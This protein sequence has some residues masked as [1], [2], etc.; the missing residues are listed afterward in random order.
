[1]AAYETEA[2]LEDKLIAQLKKL[3]YKQVTV[4][5]ACDLENHFREKL[6][7]MNKENLK[8]Q[9]LTDK[10]F[11]RVLNEMVGSLSI[12]EIGK[13]SRGSE[14]RP[15][16]KINIERDNG[17][18][19]YLTFF[20]GVDYSNNDFE[21]TH[22][23]KN[24]ENYKNRYDVTLLI[25]GLPLVQIELKHCD[26]DFGQ[27]FN[28]IIRYR[29]E[30]LNKGLFKYIQ[31]FVVSNGENTRYFSNQDKNSNSNFMFVWG[32]KNNQWLNEIHD[33]TVSFLKPVRT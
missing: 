3:G 29:S 22:Q 21:V 17:E 19:V 13:L 27:A 18:S 28:Q 12:F 8:G 5:D 4:A 23:V 20:D 24:E 10:E 1:M 9:P 11:E 15:Y 26:V 30:T 31:L 14:L 16:G 33:F 32:D 25:N 2:R 6:N 7:E